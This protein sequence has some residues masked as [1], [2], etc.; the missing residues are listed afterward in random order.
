[1]V[2]LLH[3]ACFFSFPDAPRSLPLLSAQIRL[4]LLTRLTVPQRTSRHFPKSP[5]LSSRRLFFN[6]E[7]NAPAISAGPP[8]TNDSSTYVLTVLLT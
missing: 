8:L 1:M 3:S 4:A 6:T 2:L 5:P 7:R